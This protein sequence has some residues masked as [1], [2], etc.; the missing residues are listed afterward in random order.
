MQD[1]RSWQPEVKGKK[2]RLKNYHSCPAASK[3]GKGNKQAG[4]DRAW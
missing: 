4:L 3:K 2:S 1:A